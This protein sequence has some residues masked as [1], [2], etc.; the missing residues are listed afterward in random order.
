MAKAPD[1]FE[2]TFN[3]YSVTSIVGEGGS[4][5][6]FAVKD[7]DGRVFAL[8]CLFPDRVNTERRKRFKNEIDFCSK[9]RHR[10]LIQVTDSGLAVWD[11]KK[12]PFYVM[13]LF[14]TTLRVLIDKK[15]P[16]DGV[17]PIFNQIS[18]GL[19]AAHLLGVTHRDLKPENILYDLEQNLLVI[20][21][22]GIAHFAEDII[23][24]EVAT[25]PNAKMA[26]LRYSAPEQRTKGATVDHRADIYALGLILNEM[27]TRSVP[28]GTGYTTITG[29][30]PQLG[31]LDP[32]VER[33]I[34]Q[35]PGTRPGSIEEI[36]KELIGRRN[37][38]VSL[39]QLDAK[40]REVVP[41]SSPPVIESIQLVEVDWREGTLIL[42]LNRELEPGW[43]ERFQN[44]RGNW[45]ALMGAGPENFQ[46]RGDTA[47]IRAREQD[48]Q[49]VVNHFKD[50]I[51][52]A[53]RSYQEDLEAKA[54]R[55]EKERREKLAR[56]IAEAEKRA[57]VLKN[58][59]I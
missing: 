25:E 15:L 4:G 22:F 45:S 11:G 28:Q 46:F 50:Y 52:M 9:Q 33:M 19:E 42:R 29:V 18:D 5:R 3:V 8:K 31:Y 10:N 17:L 32:L 12:C 21:D 35:N 2:S 54:A 56:E 59:K 26:N 38:F 58:L 49:Q 23:A 36:K 53:T 27:F 1:S 40:R 13:S 43:V 47:T 7:M 41:A 14:P 34:Q 24:T 6:V 48:A 39:Q 57:Q 55:E 44:P 51:Q 20:V 30:A 37:E 16:P